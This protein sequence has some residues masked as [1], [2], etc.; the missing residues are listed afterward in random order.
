MTHRQAGKSHP[1]ECEYESV[2][3]SCTNDS[4]PLRHL[5]SARK[6]LDARYLKG[7]SI[8]TAIVMISSRG[9]WSTRRYPYSITNWRTTY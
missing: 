4:Y 1:H 3:V 8:N 9:S 6:S 5:K 2:S 7:I